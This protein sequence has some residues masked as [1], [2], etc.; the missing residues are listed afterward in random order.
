MSTYSGE[1]GSYYSWNAP[2]NA[3]SVYQYSF[4]T[5]SSNCTL[6]LYR[7]HL[8]NTGFHFVNFG[9][10]GGQTTDYLM[11]YGCFN[12][13]PNSFGLYWDSQPAT[14]AQIATTQS[15]AVNIV[16]TYNYDAGVTWGWVYEGF[17]G[18]YVPGF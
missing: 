14:S 10:C 8:S 13:V 7:C 6:P 18:G 9:S 3:F 2:E 11:G 4:Q 1:G 5:G 15:E 12:Q 16:D 17:L